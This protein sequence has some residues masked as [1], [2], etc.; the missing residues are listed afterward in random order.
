VAPLLHARGSPPLHRAIGSSPLGSDLVEQRRRVIERRHAPLA[1]VLF[2]RRGLGVVVV[3]V[4]L[5][6]RAPLDRRSP[7]GA[8]CIKCAHVKTV[9]VTP[10]ARWM[11]A[12]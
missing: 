10:A 8:V 11:C 9:S 3:V 12:L 7:Y 6:L 2:R 5:R 4:V 1:Q